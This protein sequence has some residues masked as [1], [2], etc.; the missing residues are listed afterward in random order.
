[1][2]A[3][4]GMLS[5]LSYWIIGGFALYLAMRGEI[6]F[7]TFMII[8]T[9]NGILTDKIWD[10]SHIFKGMSKIVADAR[11]GLEILTEPHIIR[12]AP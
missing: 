7:A 9:Y 4:L 11:E 10:V 5:F 12:D 3:V 1:M 2:Y 8:S 6:V